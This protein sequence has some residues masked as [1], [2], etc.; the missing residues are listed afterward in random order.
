MTV[1]RYQTK[2]SK[3]KEIIENK[4]QVI[5]MKCHRM[6]INVKNHLNDS[7]TN[8]VDISRVGDKYVLKLSVCGVVLVCYIMVVVMWTK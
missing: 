8:Y 7:N 3:S 2:Q 4:E 5:K 6:Y 1:D